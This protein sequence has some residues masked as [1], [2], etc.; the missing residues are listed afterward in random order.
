MRVFFLAGILVGAASASEV[1]FS[2]ETPFFESRMV[3][4]EQGPFPFSHGSTIV[5][6]PDGRLFCAWYAGSREKGDDVIIAGGELSAGA[7]SWSEPR[8][9]VDTPGKSEGNPVLFL[10]ED[11]V[12]WLFYQTM[13]GSGEGR[14]RQGTGWTTCKVKVR[15]SD[16]GG[17]TWSDERI[18]TDELGYLTR[19]RLEVLSDGTWLLP[20]QDERNWSSRILRSIDKGVTWEMSER[21]DSGLGFHNGNIEPSLLERR[22]GSVLCLMRTGS[23][24][25]RTWRSVSTD[26]GV[27]WTQPTETEIPNPNAAL[28]LLRL[29]SGNVLMALNPVP[30]GNRILLR[31]RLSTDDG[32]TWP[33]FRDV[34]RG[35]DYSS[36]P[37]LIQGPDG[38]IHLTY[39][40]RDGG[41][42]HST[43]NEA[44]VWENALVQGEYTLSNVLP[45][46]FDPDDPRA[47]YRRKPD[48]LPI[49]VP[50]FEEHVGTTASTPGMDAL[51][52]SDLGAAPPASEIGLWIAPRLSNRQLESGASV[53][54]YL[55][56]A[57]RGAADRPTRI[58]AFVQVAD[59]IWIGS[60][61]GLYWASNA[62]SLPMRHPHY[63]VDGPLATRIAALAS[64][65]KGALWVGTPLG[66]SVRESGGSWRHIR[67]KDGLPWEDITALAFDD[68]DRL[69][70]GTT[71]G[72]IHY[73]P[74]EEGRQWFYRA[75]KRYL[76]DDHI[77]DVAVAPDGA[78]ACFATANG[79]GFI[80]SV[81]TTL[82]DKARM[83]EQR[84]GERHRRLGLVAACVL[85]D[86]RNPT[87]HHITDNDNDGL[88]TSYHVAAMS[89]CYAVTADE[90]ARESARESMHALVM[91]QNASGTPGLVARSVVSLEEGKKK[92]AQWRPTPDG[93]MYWKSDTSSDEIDGHYL[94]F[95][96]YWKHIAQFVPE[97]RALIEAQVRALT[98]YLI[99]NGYTLIDWDGKRTRWG[100]WDPKT[101]NGDEMSYL[102]SGLNS[103]QMLS[104]LKVAHYITGDE[105]YKE[106]YDRL[107]VEHGYLDN[108]L[109]GKKVFPDENNH[110]DNQL[111]FVAWYPILQLEWDPRV[112]RALQR[113]VRRHYKIVAPERSSFFNLVAATIDPDYVDIEGAI[114]NLREIPTDTRNWAM[115]NSQR[116]DVVFDPRVDRFGKRQLLHVLPADER[117]AGKWNGNPYVPDTGGDGREED[118]GAAYLLPYWM[119]RYHGFF[120]E[121]KIPR[122]SAANLSGQ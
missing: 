87:S 41:I 6:F 100:F 16:D 23:K 69:W 21:I 97:E 112:R 121:A 17:R 14:T 102:E 57:F 67:G 91:L 45:P 65:S 122:N 120:A 103:L 33:L 77:H 90:A 46:L 12:L 83:I 75:G 37:S 117:G 74:Y 84:I 34:E 110:S 42:K 66:L 36:Y 47:R 76:P 29:D 55:D 68:R 73:R 70:I 71:R 50:P 81:E 40:R 85:N 30:E 22:D 114:A 107:I 104:F 92:D 4:P 88:W 19:N 115:A 53:P 52:P 116:A 62:Q 28:D 31:L 78:T 5:A 111:G 61:E 99:L 24:R 32:A 105:K 60:D 10:G 43:F 44:W 106:H 3:C 26:G 15:T 48:E 2:G 98:D 7:T 86:A 20:M 11:G 51:L 38:R 80:K 72:A 79:V 13:Y 8:V 108:V 1:V 63:G 39:S 49:P 118:D 25:Y 54:Q 94:A 82:L 56:R 9:L 64:D 89:M 27:R 59:A 58:N 18:L 93:S 119:G 35:P 95:Y 109:L 96:T 113:A 101:L